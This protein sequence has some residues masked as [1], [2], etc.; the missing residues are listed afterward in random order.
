MRVLKILVVMAV[1]VQLTA[2]GASSWV[3]PNKPEGA[4]TE[5]YNRCES[6]VLKDPKLQQG[7]R[8]MVL[9]ATERCVMK[10]GWMIRE[11]E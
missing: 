2:C 10:K 5:D 1:V 4:F 6:D 3:H 9:E 8:Y 11:T 7:N